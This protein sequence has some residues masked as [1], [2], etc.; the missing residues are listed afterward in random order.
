MWEQ[1]SSS[2]ISVEKAYNLTRQLDYYE[3]NNV[4]T[5]D[6]SGAI[7]YLGTIATRWWLRAAYAYFDPDMFYFVTAD[8][9]YNFNYADNALG[10]TPAFRIG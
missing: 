8:G 7:K 2:Q 6:Y 9:D 1:G 4:S 3:K 10:V 5:D